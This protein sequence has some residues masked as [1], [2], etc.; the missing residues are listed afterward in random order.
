MTGI[1]LAGGRGTRLGHEKALVKLNKQS[2]IERVIERLAPVS[3]RIIIVTSREQFDHL[4]AAQLKKE[5][6]VDLYPDKGALGGLYTGLV[7]AETFYSLSVACDMPFLNVAL[8]HHLIG[9]C[10]D[11]DAVVPRTDTTLEPLHAI[12][13]KNCVGL[14]EQLWL[15]NR[16]RISELFNLANTRYVDKDE[17]SIFDP[18]YLS[19]FNI[20]TQ[21]R[22]K[23]AKALLEH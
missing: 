7:S 8:L 18:N 1:I 5:I 11:F 13:S 15:Q 22:L 19:F 16:S 3:Q 14:I 21:S 23:K 12:Y 20:N 4:N 10:P 6:V 2:L 9:L 17:I